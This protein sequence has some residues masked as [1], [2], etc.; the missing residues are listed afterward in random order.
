LAVSTSIS[1]NSCLSAS[2][3]LCTTC[4]VTVTSGFSMGVTVNPDARSTST[5]FLMLAGSFLIDSMA[6]S[7]GYAL[8][9]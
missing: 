2:G 1:R 7:T 4:A 8:W 5:F 3:I 6:I 9:S